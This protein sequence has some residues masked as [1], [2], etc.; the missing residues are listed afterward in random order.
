MQE[1][2][3]A[4]SPFAHVVVEAEVCPALILSWVKLPADDGEVSEDVWQARSL[5]YR[6]DRVFNELV[7]ADRILKVRA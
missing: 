2:T 4:R 6:G 7:A 5:Y 3:S 1:L